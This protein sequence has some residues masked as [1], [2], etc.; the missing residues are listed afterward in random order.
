[1]VL[2]EL[3]ENQKSETDGLEWR[4][5]RRW[6]RRGAR[7]LYL[8]LLSSGRQSV[9]LG[10]QLNK[11]LRDGPDAVVERSVLVVLGAEVL[12]VL[13]TLLQCCDG[14]VLSAKRGSRKS[15]SAEAARQSVPVL[16]SRG[17]RATAKG[18]EA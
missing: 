2:H 16:S 1:M 12:L 9:D 17:H 13:L 3:Q 6:T 15:G 5:G 14:V 10:A 8:V 4:A 18:R 11:H 7:R